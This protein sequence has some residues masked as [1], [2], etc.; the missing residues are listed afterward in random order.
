MNV[1]KDSGFDAGE[2]E[3]KGT[4]GREK[5]NPMTKHYFSSGARLT[6]IERGSTPKVG[7]LPVSAF[8]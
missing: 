8:P 7:V 1:C 3:I 4:L 2:F 5:K 6:A